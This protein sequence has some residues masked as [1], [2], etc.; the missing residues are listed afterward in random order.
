MIPFI[1]GWKVCMATWPSLSAEALNI[2]KNLTTQN[3]DSLVIQLDKSSNV[4]NY[5]I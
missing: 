3:S 1:V 5:A 4:T 2:K